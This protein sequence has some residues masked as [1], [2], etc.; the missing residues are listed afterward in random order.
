MGHW[1]RQMQLRLVLTRATETHVVVLRRT[2][3]FSPLRISVERSRPLLRQS[4]DR[5]NFLPHVLKL[6]LK[7]LVFD[8]QVFHDVI[9][10]TVISKVT[11]YCYLQLSRDCP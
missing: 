3:V 11:V 9:L 2:V 6:S 10:Q 8:A 7:V 1:L 4:F 5:L